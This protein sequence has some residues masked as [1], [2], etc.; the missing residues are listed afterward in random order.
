M[1]KVW[2]ILGGLILLIVIAAA[3]STKQDDMQYRRFLLQDRAV[4]GKPGV[5]VVAL[6]QPEEYDFEFFDRYMTQIFN[7]AF[8]PALKLLIM[9]DS[10]TVLLDPDD[11]TAVRGVRAEKAD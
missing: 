3:F 5:L 2:L 11:V 4:E 6:G 10:G 8:P 9:G 1:K 7:A